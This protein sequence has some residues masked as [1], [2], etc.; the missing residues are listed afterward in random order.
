MQLKNLKIMM[1]VTMILIRILH[2]LNHLIL[3]EEGKK[4][5]GMIIETED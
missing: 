5:I 4:L 2:I 1:I 3:K